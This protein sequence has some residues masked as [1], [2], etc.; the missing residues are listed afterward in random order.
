MGAVGQSR[1]TLWPQTH[2]GHQKITELFDICKLIECDVKLEKRTVLLAF[3][4]FKARK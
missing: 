3:K 2:H 4:H 1:N